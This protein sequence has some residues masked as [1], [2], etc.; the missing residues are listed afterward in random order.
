M[1]AIDKNNLHI[2]NS[3]LENLCTLMN[4]EISWNSNTQKISLSVGAVITNKVTNF[5][6][7]YHKA[8]EILYEVKR[9]GRN[10]FKIKE[11]F[12]MNKNNRFTCY[13]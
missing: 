3:R 13:N 2:I 5:D 4:K 1:K 11:D 12:E 7:L 8:D 10:G 6:D 9:N